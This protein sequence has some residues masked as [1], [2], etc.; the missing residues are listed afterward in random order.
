MWQLKSRAWGWALIWW[1]LFFVF[2]PLAAYVSPHFTVI[3]GGWVLPIP[4]FVWFVYRQ[5]ELYLDSRD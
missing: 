2:W 4:A 3:D 1:A 5:H